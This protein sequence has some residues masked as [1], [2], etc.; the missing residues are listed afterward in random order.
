MNKIYCFGF[1]FFSKN[2]IRR[3][4]ADEKATLVFVRSAT[5]AINKGFDHS[6][7]IA[8]WG[9]RGEQQALLL[10]AQFGVPVW[11]VEDGFIRSSGLGSDYS[12]PASLVIDKQGIYY[13]PS[14]A[15]ELESILQSGT[16]DEDLLIRAQRIRQLLVE[17]S[18]SK[19]NLGSSLDDNLK[20]S[21]KGKTVVLI[22]GQVEDD[23]SIQ[24]GTVDIKT[25]T[26]LIKKVSH[27]CKE[28]KN[29]K[30]RKD[31]FV[32]YKPHPD[33]VSGNR[34]GHVDTEVTQQYCDAVLDDVS[35]TD[36]LAI[37]NE[38]HT[39]TSLVGMEALMRGCKVFCYGLPFYACWGLTE[40]QYPLA[41]RT[42]RVSLAEL[43]AGTYILYPRYMDWENN[44]LC[45]A[46]CAIKQMGEKIQ[47]QGGKQLNKVSRVRRQL[48]KLVN[49]G[50]GV[51]QSL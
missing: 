7:G 35:I 23:A 5:M 11:R 15:S 12:P 28:R 40:D 49:M 30:E 9:K 31:V 10:S 51:L 27:L 44:R 3:F 18:I 16:F 39:M 34:I 46:E 13:D 25:N 50:R 14:K 42:R 37:A 8:S 24:K 22:P 17:Q 41:R 20:Q 43:L 21:I 2:T 33:V 38:V 32:I 45:T 26:D 19:Y 48:R 4:F 36:C 47:Q 1:L 29:Y 6:S